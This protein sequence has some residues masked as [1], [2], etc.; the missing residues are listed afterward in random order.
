MYCYFQHTPHVDSVVDEVEQ[1][2]KNIS[3]LN[4]TLT[5][6]PR[7]LRQPFKR[8]W[9]KEKKKESTKKK[10][11]LNKGWRIKSK[12]RARRERRDATPVMDNIAHANI[13]Y[14]ICVRP[15]VTE[16]HTYK[17]TINARTHTRARARAHEKPSQYTRGGVTTTIS[18]GT[19]F[20][21][22]CLSIAENWIGVI[23]RMESIA[24]LGASR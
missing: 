23:K 24:S 22:I 13:Y 11:K 20:V 18:F 7:F 21:F 5:W 9:T 8:S 16:I 4:D 14:I 2:R 6:S 19:L 3:I 1:K 15:Y 12:R 17:N 10:W